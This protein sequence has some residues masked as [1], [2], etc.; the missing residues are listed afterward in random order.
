MIT[1]PPSAS[2]LASL[3]TAT[4]H[5]QAHAGD[6]EG[7]LTNRGY[8][9]PSFGATWRLGVVRDPLPGHEQMLGRLAIPSIGPRGVR[10][11]RFR[12]LQVHDCKEQGCP[13]YLGLPGTATSV[14]NTRALHTAQSFIAV[15]EGELDAVALNESGVPAVAIVGANNWK[16]F[17]A[18]LFGGFDQVF[19]CGD[20]DDAGRAFNLK[21]SASVPGVT[22]VAMGDGK[23]ISDIYRDLGAEG[24]RDVVHG[25][26]PR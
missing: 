10:S 12:C 13:K 3:E 7:W 19:V 2:S 5:Y 1:S 21:V 15:A 22:I 25:E 26:D 20:G 9:G 14:F 4:A 23:D 11:I 16:P 8:T 24:V 6:A 18:R 17:Y